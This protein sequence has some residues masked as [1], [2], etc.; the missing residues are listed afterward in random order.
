MRRSALAWLVFA[1]AVT[2]PLMAQRQPEQNFFEQ[3]RSLFGRFQDADLRRAFRVAEPVQCSQ[4]VSGT[5]E[6]RPV[7]FFN[8]D[9]KQG[10]WFHRSLEEVN[11]D[12]SLYTFKGECSKDQDS[13][14]LATKFP[15]QDSVERYYAG[16]IG[17]KDVDIKTNPPVKA[18]YIARS[19]G[20]RFELPYMY[21]GRGKDVYSLAPL[22]S[23]DRHVADVINHWE[24]KSVTG[25]DVTF[26]FL[27]CETATLFRNFVRGTEGEQ[28]F[29]AYAY[30]I[31]SDGKE[32]RTSVKLSFG[33]PGGDETPAPPL[34]RPVVAEADDSVEGW[35]IPASASKLAEVDKTEF[36][37][38]FNA[39]TWVDKIGSAQ[40]L[41]GQKV[42]SLDP[43]KSP[44]GVDYCTWRPAAANMASRV[45]GNE[46]DANVSYTLRVT[47]TSIGIEMKTHNGTRVGMLQC[48]FQGADTAAAPFSRWVAVV[49]EH[50]TV[51]VRP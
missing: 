23:T 18:T 1:L 46:P 14:E 39:Q 48:F 33:A 6:W 44:T 3:L 26:Q 17:L 11:A 25:N 51:E 20:Y 5:G 29:G 43:L 4:L 34:D 7:A 42:S 47:D 24:C 15:V 32:A 27:I 21:A 40:L 12:L 36:R 37:I 8:E 13:V 19:Q 45:L 9:R 35:Q 31:L 49:G 50:L 38:R 41:S 10:A 30:Y 16:R 2:P 22:R 28:A